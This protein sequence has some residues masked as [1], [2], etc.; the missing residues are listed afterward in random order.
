MCLA[1]IHITN[2][3]NQEASL[4]KE[5]ILALEGENATKNAERVTLQRH[6]EYLAGE[7]NKLKEKVSSLPNQ[8]QLETLKKEIRHL[9]NTN[10]HNS[11][12]NNKK[13]QERGDDVREKSNERGEESSE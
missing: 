13:K 6:L 1:I 10:K 8:F 12:S 2:D 7:N 5:Y 4:L 11:P 3:M 9:K